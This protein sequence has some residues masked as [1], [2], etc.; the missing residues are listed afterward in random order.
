MTE[1]IEEK[2]ALVAGATRDAGRDIPVTVGY[3]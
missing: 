2:V 1:Y 3:R